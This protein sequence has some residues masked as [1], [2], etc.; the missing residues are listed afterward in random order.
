[1]SELSIEEIRIIKKVANGE[2]MSIIDQ[3]TLRKL[4]ITGPFDER[5]KEAIGRRAEGKETSSDQ[6]IIELLHRS[7]PLLRS[8]DD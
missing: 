1:M 3:M 8:S 6:D 7:H 5:T 2:R 4:A